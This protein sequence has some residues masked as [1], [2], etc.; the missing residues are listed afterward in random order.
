MSCP[1]SGPFSLWEWREKNVLLVSQMDLLRHATSTHSFKRAQQS[2]WKE[3]T[4][5]NRF[6]LFQWRHDKR[7]ESDHSQ[8]RC[9][10]SEI[11]PGKTKALAHLRLRLQVIRCKWK[12]EGKQKEEV[13]DLWI[14]NA[15]HAQMQIDTASCV[16]NERMSMRLLLLGLCTSKAWGVSNVPAYFTSSKA[17]RAFF[18]SSF[19]VNRS[20]T[21]AYLRESFLTEKAKIVAINVG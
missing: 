21:R 7:R 3:K 14:V 10:D 8:S 2:G 20:F 16:V 6:S 9:N 15:G 5:I 11:C 4:E 1:S 12:R 18:S 19:I 13:R 17:F